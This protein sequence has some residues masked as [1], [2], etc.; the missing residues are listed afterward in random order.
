MYVPRITTVQNSKITNIFK[1]KILQNCCKDNV[2]AAGIAAKKSFKGS[3]KKVF[4]GLAGPSTDEHEPLLS[5]ED[6]TDT[7]PV[8]NSGTTMI[9]RFWHFIMSLSY[10]ICPCI[11]DAQVII[12]ANEYPSDVDT[13]V[14]T[15]FDDLHKS[16]DIHWF[17][18]L[19]DA[20]HSKEGSIKQLQNTKEERVEKEYNRLI[21]A[22]K[23]ESIPTTAS[24]RHQAFV[25]V[26]NYIRLEKEKIDREYDRK[27]DLLYVQHY[28]RIVEE[29]IEMLIS[30]WKRMRLTTSST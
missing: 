21:G 23:N 15:A 14:V 10:F 2:A 6:H 1:F 16:Q 17:R 18:Q 11:S 22:V 9:N 5:K 3:V 7:E 24:Y 25:N 27:V 12:P 19:Q 28:H 30:F 13:K 29:Q 4:S 26:R 8:A 20:R